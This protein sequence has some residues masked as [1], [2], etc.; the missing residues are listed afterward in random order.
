[1]SEQNPSIPLSPKKAK[2][3]LSWEQETLQRLAFSALKE[4][5]RARRWSIFFKILFFA[6]LITVLWLYSLDRASAPGISTPHTALIDIDGVITA[7]LP[8][9]AENIKKGL[10][11]A[12]ENEHTTGVILRINSPGGSPV[13]AGYI[14]DE[15][16]RLHQKHSKIPIYAVITDICASGGYYIAV[17]ADKIYADKASL[18]GSIGVLLNS[19]GFV[20]AMEKLGIERRLFTAG[21]HKGFLDPFSPTAESDRQHIQKMLTNIHEQFI[22]KVKEGRGDRLKDDPSLFSGLV[23]TGEEA[24]TLGLID[25]LGSSDY[26]AH[27]I[28]KTEKIVD[29]TSKPRLLER[30]ANQLGATLSSALSSFISSQIR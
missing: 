30:F 9:S 7:D 20:E 2:E 17:A 29:Y 24:L 4:Q 23:W 1:M 22:Q 28:L 10:Q 25:G 5:Q 13:Q 26:V 19:F 16:H 6:Y 14:N 11:A 18:V 3:Q 15:I 12:F 21:D 27:E 8:A